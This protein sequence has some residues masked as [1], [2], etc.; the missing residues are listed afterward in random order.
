MTDF[1]AARL[2]MVESQIRPNKVTDRD[3]IDT[4]E[5]LPREL[6][7][8]EARRGLA[9]IDEDLEVTAGRHLLEPMVLARL[10][11]AADILPEDMILDVACGS[12]YS[13]AVIAALGSTVV[14]LEE[15]EALVTMANDVLN[16]LEIDNAVVVQGRLTEGYEKQA[17]YNVILIGGAVDFV[18]EALLAQL[19]EG[20]RLVTVIRDEAGLG[21]AT[22]IQRD[23]AAT[24]R[25]VLFDA[26][27]TALS[28]FAREQGFV[29]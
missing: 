2:N 15:D 17:P 10:V 18:P 3:L 16:E 23:G 8:P 21:R 13:T 1:A 9:Y 12:G 5:K 29:F 20:G 25:R 22:L 4:L 24:S 26:N 11:Q 6:F 14:A 27:V 19:A 28:A 7:V